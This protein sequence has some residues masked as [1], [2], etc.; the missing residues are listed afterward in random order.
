MK[1]NEEIVNK[2]LAMAARF[3]SIMGYQSKLGFKFYDSTHPTELKCWQMAVD[4]FDD[5]VSIDV[6][7]A[8]D[9]MNDD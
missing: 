5:L 1:T 6:N 4:A 9:D 7:A 3:Y 8:L 2:A